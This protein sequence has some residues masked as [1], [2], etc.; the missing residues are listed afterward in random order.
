[1]KLDD[2]IKEEIDVISEKWIRYLLLEIERFYEFMDDNFHFSGMY[3]DC[4]YIHKSDCTEFWWDGVLVF[5]ATIS[6]RKMKI[7]FTSTRYYEVVQV[8]KL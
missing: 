7:Q 4:W 3:K 2:Y 1:M 5:K 6:L 8:R